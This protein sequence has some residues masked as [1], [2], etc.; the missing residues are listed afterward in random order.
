MVRELPCMNCFMSHTKNL[1]L[2]QCWCSIISCS[3]LSVLCLSHRRVSD[4]LGSKDREVKSLRRQL[5][6]TREEL[7][8]CTRDRDACVR[9]NRRLQEDLATMTRENQVSRDFP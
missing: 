1:I 7:T 6:A 5:D 8:E 4:E 3:T 9:E 2:T